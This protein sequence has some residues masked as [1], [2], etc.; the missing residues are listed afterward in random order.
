MAARRRVLRPAE[1]HRDKIERNKRLRSWYV[2][3]GDQKER[4]EEIK[5]IQSLDTDREVA[6]YLLDRELLW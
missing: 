6:K 4:L 1:K 3:K 2:T 5:G